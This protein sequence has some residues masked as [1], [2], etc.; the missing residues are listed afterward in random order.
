MILTDIFFMASYIHL[1]LLDDDISETNN[2]LLIV[3]PHKFRAMDTLLFLH[4]TEFWEVQWINRKC[5]VM[6]NYVFII[7]L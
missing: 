3:Q 1:F 4:G 6:Q 2:R 7:F 5:Y